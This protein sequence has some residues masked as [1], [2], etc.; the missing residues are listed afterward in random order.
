MNKKAGCLLRRLLCERL[1]LKL[2]FPANSRYVPPYRLVDCLPWNVCL[3][4]PA[5]EGPHGAWP[6]RRL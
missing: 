5:I 2:E 4:G 3:T 6:I 1:L